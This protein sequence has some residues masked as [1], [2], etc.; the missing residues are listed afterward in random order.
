LTKKKKKRHRPAHESLRQVYSCPGTGQGSRERR[1]GAFKLVALSCYWVFQGCLYLTNWGL[2]ALAN[3]G[4]NGQGPRVE[5]Q[6]LLQDTSLG[7]PTRFLVARARARVWAVF[8]QIVLRDTL[9]VFAA[10]RHRTASIKTPQRLEKHSRS[11]IAFQGISR[12]TVAATNPNA[13][14]SWCPADH[15]FR[16]RSPV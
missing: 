1:N 7:I 14:P 12:D 8:P 3:A 15:D 9:L 5:E 13:Q 4:H 2:V 11:G 6:G 10:V 16:P